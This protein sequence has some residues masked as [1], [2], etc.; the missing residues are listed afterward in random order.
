[1]SQ[2]LIT[3]QSTRATEN[4]G[5]STMTD[6]VRSPV[7]VVTDEFHHQ[8]A[9]EARILRRCIPTD[10]DNRCGVCS[11]L[12]PRA[13]ANSQVKPYKFSIHRRSQITMHPI[14]CSVHGSPH[15]V[16][17]LSPSPSIQQVP[18]VGPSTDE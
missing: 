13:G 4:D 14:S 15:G 16:H 17:T 8:C 2:L 1:M 11:V 18:V 9:A 3:N 5:K 7:L 10:S 12:T 6:D